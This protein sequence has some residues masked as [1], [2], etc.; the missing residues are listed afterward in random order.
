[1]K[2]QWKE[3]EIEAI[4]K[5]AYSGDKIISVQDHVGNGIK[6]PVH[7]FCKKTTFEYA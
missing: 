5:G 2:C 6:Y 3:L 4:A 1:M 7:K